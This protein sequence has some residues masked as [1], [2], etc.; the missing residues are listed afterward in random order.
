MKITIPQST[1]LTAFG[2]AR[3]YKLLSALAKNMP[4]AYFLNALR[5]LHKGASKRSMVMNFTIWFVIT[6]AIIVPVA[7]FIFHNKE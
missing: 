4:P 7:T 6:I 2:S 3:N 5:P 1:S